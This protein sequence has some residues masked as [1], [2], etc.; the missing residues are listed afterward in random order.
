ML[1][2]DVAPDSVV[3]FVQSGEKLEQTSCSYVCSELPDSFVTLINRAILASI[4]LDPDSMETTPVSF[5]ALF[6]LHY[7]TC[8][9]LQ[10]V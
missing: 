5:E 1:F 8:S 7:L 4:Y 10:V 6:S 3:S 2:E 9:F